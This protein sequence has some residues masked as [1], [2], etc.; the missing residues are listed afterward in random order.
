[1]APWAEDFYEIP[2]VVSENEELQNKVLELVNDEPIHGKVTEGGDRTE[3]LREIL[4][5]FF[6]LDISLEEGI[7]EVSSELPRRESPHASNNRVFPNGWAERLVRTQ[8]SRFY[9]QAVLLILKDR[10]EQNCFVPHSSEE[11]FES[12][13]TQMLAGNEVEI[14]P[15]L[16]RLERAHG[17]GEWHEEVMIPDHPH[18]THAIVPSS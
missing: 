15:L 9:N 10:G 5:R 6:N 8:V 14:G 12:N 2:N 11:D 13:C 4:A 16:N 17:E 1:M 7:R 3:S 18:C